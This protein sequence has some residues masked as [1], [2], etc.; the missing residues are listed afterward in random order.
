MRSRSPLSAPRPRVMLVAAATVALLAAVGCSSDDVSNPDPAP[1]TTETT[2]A[3]SD[4]AT[5][6]PAGDPEADHGHDS[7]GAA[8]VSLLSPADGDR[9]YGP[10]TVTMAAEGIEIAPAGDVVEGSGHFHLVVDLPCV[11]EGVSIPKDANHVHFGKG[12]TEATV[13]LPAGRHE[14][15]LQVGDGVHVAQDITDTITVEV[16]VRDQTEWCDVAGAMND[17]ITTAKFADATTDEQ[18]SELQATWLDGA[19]LLD[20]LIKGIEHV[21]EEHRNDVDIMVNHMWDKAYAIIDAPNREAAA[22]PHEAL[23]AAEP[24]E[25]GPATMWMATACEAQL[26]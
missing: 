10:V 26:T 17:T 13:F 16:G 8:S 23:R 25:M 22:E 7:P 19:A 1:E 3:Q 12:Q 5:G 14:L 15:C 2:A 24:A 6:E 20:Q 9:L 11:D 18:F 4:E 21:D